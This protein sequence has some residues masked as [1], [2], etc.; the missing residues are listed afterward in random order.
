MGRSWYLTCM[1]SQNESSFL[2]GKDESLLWSDN[3]KL[4]HE[5]VEMWY[6]SHLPVNINRISGTTN[7]LVLLFLISYIH[8]V[9]NML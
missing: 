5:I 9:N 4:S 1:L 3:A 2:H 8:L 7:S 6:S